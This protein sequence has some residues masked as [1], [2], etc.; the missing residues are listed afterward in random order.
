MLLKRTGWY[1]IFS[2]LVTTKHVL[3]F[4]ALMSFWSELVTNDEIFSIFIVVYYH[5]FHYF[6]DLHS[7]A[8]LYVDCR[9]QTTQ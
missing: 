4:Y 7:F 2:Q 9:T 3:S 5:E 1:L 8:V 6:K